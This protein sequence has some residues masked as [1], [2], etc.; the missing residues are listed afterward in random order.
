VDHDMP[1]G[2]ARVGVQEIVAPLRAALV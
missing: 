2:R 1:G